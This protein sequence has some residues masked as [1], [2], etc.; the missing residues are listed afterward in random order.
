[1]KYIK[2][3]VLAGCA[4]VL[5]SAC[6]AGVDTQTVASMA[7]PGNP[8][9][10][11]LKSEYTALAVLEDEEAD[12]ADAMFF[13]AKAKSSA[14][15]KLTGP[16]RVGDRMI[17]AAFID[18][19]S[20]ARK[21]LVKALNAGV[22]K[23][24]PKEAARAQAMFDCWMQE[25]EEGTQPKDIEQCRSAFNSAFAMLK[26]PVMVKEMPKPM[27]MPNPFVVYFASDSADLT[28]QASATLKEVVAASKK[29]KPAKIAVIGHTDTQGD[30]DY[31]LGL[32]RQRA[33][34]VSNSLMEMGGL[35]R[36]QV[37]RK[38][39]GEETPAIAT[40]DNVNEGKNRRVTIEFMN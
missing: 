32:S 40:G 9:L 33:S 20:M 6:A 10:A 34:A 30:K 37:I 17:G 15:G 4:A 14:E 11:A 19:L 18:E 7:S 35:T 28:M 27:M 23:S 21:A 26:A 8:F 36:D 12:E 5:L 13:I 29:Y 24:M 3:P 38:R 2:I 1:M 16:Q 25:Q 39:M 31:N 22:D